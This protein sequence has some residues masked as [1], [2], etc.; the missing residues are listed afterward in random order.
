M[1]ERESRPQREAFKAKQEVLPFPAI[2]QIVLLGFAPVAVYLLVDWIG[3]VRTAIGASVA[4]AVIVFFVQRRLRKQVGV[5]F[6]LAMLGL[7]IFIASGAAGLILDSGKA[8]WASDPIEDFIVGG[9]FAVSAVMGRPILSPVIRELFPQ[10]ADRLPSQHRVFM[11]ITVV[12]AV[13]ILLMGVLRVWL[14]DTLDVNDYVWLRM[15]IGW[16]INLVIFVWTAHRI[17]RAMR[18]HSLATAQI[19]E[20]DEVIR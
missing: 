12:W 3:D 15:L 14:L 10:I 9:I 19:Q 6:K 20:S 1:T 5:V 17:Q 16:P 11:L 4:A 13:K 18:E 2:D 7:A 8:L